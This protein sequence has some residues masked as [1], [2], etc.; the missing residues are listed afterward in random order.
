VAAI[1][2]IHILDAVGTY[3]STRWIFWA[4]IAVIAAATQSRCH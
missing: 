1:G 4:H 3:E 2:V